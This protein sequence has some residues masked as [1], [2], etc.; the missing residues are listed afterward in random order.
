MIAS[1]NERSKKRIRRIQ[2]SALSG[3][4]SSGAVALVS[5]FSAPITI[6]YLGKDLYA[7]WVLITSFTI[8]AQLFDFGILNGLTNALAEAFGRDDYES[9]QK[10]INTSFAA[11]AA[12][13]VVGIA[14]W[15]WISSHIPWQKFIRVDTLEQEILLGKGICIVGCCFLGSL[16]FLLFSRIL[17][18][19]QRQYLVHGTQFIAYLLS[20]CALIIGVHYR[21]EVL[22]L[23]LFISIFPLIWQILCWLLLTK[24]ISWARLSWT[25]IKYS[26]L[27]RVAHSSIPLLVLQL[28]NIL[29]SQVIPITLTAVTTLK[30]VADFH[31]LWKIYLFI[32]LMMTNV[33]SALN[34][35]IRDA[36]ERGEIDWIKRALK[37]LLAFQTSLIIIGCLPL[38]FAGNKIIEF[39]IRMPLEKPL[40]ISGWLIFTLCILFGVLNTALNSC[41]LILDRIA[42]QILL[43]LLSSSMVF[44]AICWGVP[45]T[46]LIIIFGSMALCAC[47]SIM[48]SFRALRIVLKT[49]AE[50][51]LIQ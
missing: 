43:A 45:K 33:S 18:A 48:Y 30:N 38:L 24:K 46:G 19:Y 20:L 9:A 21:F 29:T 3:L 13:S 23:L 39:W 37:R 27:K 31:I 11:A 5:I 40:E 1:S 44:I 35:G 51:S 4:A 8:W 32:S 12:I 6:N 14:A 34:P 49:K 25:C 42:L 17:H 7:I 41:L 10:Y 16:P 47:I 15:M 28:I 26:A 50:R 36:F 22:R 2:W